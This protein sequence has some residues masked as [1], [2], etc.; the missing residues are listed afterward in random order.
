MER[1]RLLQRGGNLPRGRIYAGHVS[2]PGFLSDCQWLLRLEQPVTLVLPTLPERHFDA[3]MALV[4]ALSHREGFECSVNDFGAL[5]AIADR[6]PDIPLAAGPLLLP[7]DTDPLLGVFC[8]ETETQNPVWTAE[9][10]ATLTWAAP[11]ETCIRHWQD[12]SVFSAWELLRD[13]GV[14]R[15]EICAQPKM[16]QAAPPLPVSLYRAS[17][18][19]VLPCRACTACDAL[20]S[21]VRGGKQLL[22]DRNLI[23]YADETPIPLFADRVIDM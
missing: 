20:P 17:M 18:L 4:A 21:P 8:T 5:L 7:Q 23:W 13:C 14:S 16:P 3:A 9:G 15:L 19:S 6:C 11:P 22:H 12:P 10:A 1:Y 2:C